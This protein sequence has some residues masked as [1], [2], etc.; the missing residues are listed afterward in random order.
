[1]GICK[2]KD[3]PLL[4]WT[5]NVCKL[6]FDI[7]FNRFTSNLKA[8]PSGQVRYGDNCYQRS[9]SSDSDIFTNANS[10]LDKMASLWS[11]ETSN[12]VT[13]VTTTFPSTSGIY[14]LGIEQYIFGKGVYHS[15]HSYGV[16]LPFYTGLHKWFFGWKG[17]IWLFINV[18]CS[19]SILSSS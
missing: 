8:C 12:E 13:F 3:Y 6:R 17:K 14:H 4:P 1:M 16:G 5:I 7:C 18:K 2:L 9:G 19:P 11:P 15:D 10:C